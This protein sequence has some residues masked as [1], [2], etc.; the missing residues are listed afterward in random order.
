MQGGCS[1][2]LATL[3]FLRRGGLLATLPLTR[4]GGRLLRWSRLLF[5]CWRLTLLPSMGSGLGPWGRVPR[6]RPQSSM[7]A[8]YVDVRIEKGAIQQFFDGSGSCRQGRRRRRSSSCGVRFRLRRHI[9]RRRFS[10]HR[11]PR[12]WASRHLFPRRGFFRR[13]FPRHRFPRCRPFRL[14][15]ISSW[16]RRERRAT[17]S[18]GWAGS[19]VSCAMRTGTEVCVPGRDEAADP[20]GGSA[21]AATVVTGGMVTNG[22]RPVGGLAG[23]APRERVE[24]AG[25]GRRTS[26]RR[27]RVGAVCADVPA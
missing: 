26:C 16:C 21:S 2:L 12:C 15:P 23:V 22:R 20:W 5:W 6:G 3:P 27:G 1:F 11:F 8:W 17:T 4:W 24:G 10:R 19:S 18:G 13:L 25:E 7:I 9:S 14:W